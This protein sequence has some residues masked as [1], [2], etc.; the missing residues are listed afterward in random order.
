MHPGVEELLSVY[1]DVVQP[2]M[3]SLP[4]FNEALQVEAV[5]FQFHQ[6]RPCGVIIT[7]W[8]MNLVVLPAEGDDWET[9]SPGEDVTLSFPGGDYDCTASIV[10]GLG[11]HLALPLF[12]T[13]KDFPDHETAVRIARDILQRLRGS[14]DDPAGDNAKTPQPGKSGWPWPLS[15]RDL[16]LGKPKPGK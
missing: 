16:L 8:F 9:L 14:H 15:R 12:T 6:D 5:D 2:R 3:S 13:V 4:M 10:E 7:P 11:T 1:R